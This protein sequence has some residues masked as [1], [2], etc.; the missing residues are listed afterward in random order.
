MPNMGFVESCGQPLTSVFN[1][2]DHCFIS[3]EIGGIFGR[4]EHKHDC[5]ITKARAILAGS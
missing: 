3:S 5:A 4:T 2:A 1:I